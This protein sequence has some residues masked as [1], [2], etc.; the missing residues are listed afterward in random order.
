M[1]TYLIRS[2]K[3]NSAVCT[4]NAERI[5]EKWYDLLEK[6]GPDK[7]IITTTA[8]VKIDIKN[9]QEGAT[10]P[11]ESEPEPEPVDNEDTEWPW[12][13]IK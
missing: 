7:F 2:S 9:I 6:W 4:G 1:D 11:P 13:I 10:N 5:T 8:G 3:H 12:Q